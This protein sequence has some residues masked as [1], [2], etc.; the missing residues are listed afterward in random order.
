MSVICLKIQMIVKQI[1][2]QIFN[3]HNPYWDDQHSS[4]L[5]QYLYMY[6]YAYTLCHS[7][8]RETIVTRRMQLKQELNT[9]P[10]QI[11]SIFSFLCIVLST[12]ACLLFFLFWP[13]HSACLSSIYGF[14]YP[15]IL[16]LFFFFCSLKMSILCLS[17]QSL[18]PLTTSNMVRDVVHNN[19]LSKWYIY[20]F[21]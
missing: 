14:W 11:V 6:T 17:Y 21:S 15:S 13:L 8:T 9:L 2:R 4:L 20:G 7:S 10:E 19:I 12:N 16:Y 3:R 18:N 1:S 5:E